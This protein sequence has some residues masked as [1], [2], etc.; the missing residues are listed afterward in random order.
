V[1][2]SSSVRQPLLGLVRLYAGELA[3]QKGVRRARWLAGALAIVTVL[4]MLVHLETAAD[5]MLTAI[6]ALGWLSWLVGGAVVW[7]AVRNW[8]TFQE[9]L[10]DMERERGLDPTWRDL[11]APLALA[12]QLAV[13]IGLPALLLTTLSV[14]L[15]SS[16]EFA[17]AYPALLVLVPGYVIVFAL[18]F[19]LLG[20]L[21]AK[22][23]PDAPTS[24]LLCIL[25]I[26]HVCRELWPYTPSV[27]GFYEWLWSE[28]AHL[29]ASV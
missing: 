10:A 28:L 8:K 20:Y 17:W 22:L 21:S 26:P 7:S 13:M 25:V 24:V 1:S 6:E 16:T 15:A 18:G 29:G 19:G 5:V 9:P 4:S 2:L 12:R 3:L 14:A 23:A 11:A 27:I